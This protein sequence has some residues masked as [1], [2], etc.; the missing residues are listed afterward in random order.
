MK[1]LVL[2]LLA[3][4]VLTPTYSQKSIKIIK[5]ANVTRIIKTLSADDMMGRPAANPLVMEKATSF[6]ENEFK[7][8]FN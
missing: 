8:A 5:S 2:A 7:H 4:T 1:K 3:L 6:I